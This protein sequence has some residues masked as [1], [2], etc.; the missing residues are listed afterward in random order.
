[1]KEFNAEQAQHYRNFFPALARRENDQPVVFFDGP[2]GTQVPMVVV[3]AINEY[4]LGCNANHGGFFE[5]SVQ[6]DQ[7][8]HDAHRACADFVG[9]DDPNEIMFGQ[10]MTSLTF[11]LSRALSNSWQPDDE[12]IV[13]KLDHDAN[14][15]PWVLAAQDKGVKVHR[16]PFCDDDCTLDLDQLKSLLNEKTKLVAVGCASNATGGINPVKQ[17]CE[18]AHAHS[19][20]VYLDAVHYGPHGLIDVQ[21]WGLSLIHI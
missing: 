17:I 6:S 8:L 13:T 15:S 19:A 3:D 16:A 18:L 7:W 11:S 9:T 5:T 21:E 1:M 12:I 4:L 10:N 14:V 20:L 2:A